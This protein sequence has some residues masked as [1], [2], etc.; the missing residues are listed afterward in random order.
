MWDHCHLGKLCDL[1]KA[2]GRFESEYSAGP[3]AVMWFITHSYL[4]NPK[5]KYTEMH[6]HRPLAWSTFVH[7]S[8]SINM[9]IG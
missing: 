1:Q 5:Q 7:A 8:D 4:N 2:C 3:C 6:K 9:L